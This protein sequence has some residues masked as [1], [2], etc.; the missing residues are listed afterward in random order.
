[1]TALV[2]T[3]AARARNERRQMLEQVGYRVFT[4]GSF[5]EGSALLKRIR[6]DLLMVDVRLLEYNGVHL[7]LR[8]REE[9][10]RT[11][12]VIVGEPDIVLEREAAAIGALYLSTS[13]VRAFLASLHRHA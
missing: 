12:T 13:D 11:R 1:M 10:P 9:T 2:V 5:A 8:A 7:A 3:V 4:A 6:P